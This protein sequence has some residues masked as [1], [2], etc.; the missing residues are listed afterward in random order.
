MLRLDPLFSL[1]VVVRD[2]RGEVVLAMSKNANTTIPLQA[3]AETILWA[4][5]V[6]SE[7][8]LKAAIIESD[9]KSCM[10]AINGKI[11]EIS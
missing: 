6:A 3:K 2:W 9:S 7:L 5:S 8:D 4:T 11:L 10:D 1:V